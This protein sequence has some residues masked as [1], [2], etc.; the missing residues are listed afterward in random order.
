MNDRLMVLI[1]LFLYFIIAVCGLWLLP[2]WIGI[3]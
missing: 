3:E 1:A 2:H